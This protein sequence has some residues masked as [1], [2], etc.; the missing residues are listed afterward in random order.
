M[1][2]C[3]FHG[4]ICY[5]RS[6]IRI[7]KQH[8]SKNYATWY[9][10][11]WSRVWL[12]WRKHLKVQSTNANQPF[13]FYALETSK[14]ACMWKKESKKV[15]R[16]YVLI[17]QSY[18]DQGTFD[19]QPT[20]NSWLEDLETCRKEMFVDTPEEI[21]WESRKNICAK[22][23]HMLSKC[24]G[25]QLVICACPRPVMSQDPGWRSRHTTGKIQRQRK[26][27]EKSRDMKIR[28]L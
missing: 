23:A 1:P 17:S 2:L 18:D 28:G 27:V 16:P 10:S 15:V 20:E 5:G 7:S 4:T 19:R 8:H 24:A 13:T 14:A 21:W 12:S 25:V 3:I 11:V 22:A 6:K 26:V 9:M